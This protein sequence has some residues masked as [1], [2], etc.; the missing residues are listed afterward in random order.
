MWSAY[1]IILLRLLLLIVGALATYSLVSAS[2]VASSFPPDALL[3]CCYFTIANTICLVLIHKNFRKNNQSWRQFIGFDRALILKDLG[4]AILWFFL[5]YIPFVVTILGV[6]LALY[7]VDGFQKLETAFIPPEPAKL[8][9]TSTM[10]LTLIAGLLFPITNAP[11]EEILFRGMALRN[12]RV[13]TAVALTLQAVVF[14]LH[15]LLLAPT[16]LALIIYA[17]AFFLW[18]LGAGIIATVQ[19]RL[20][21]IIAAH[22]LVNTIFTLPSV[23][24]V[25]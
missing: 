1:R 15:H 2:G 12:T 3:A 10:L 25:L 17:I 23:F 16:Q 11:T 24:F 6:P 8:S 4:W 21:P 18:G 7:G 19:Q 20:M 13:N 22:L 5:L 9:A 14:S